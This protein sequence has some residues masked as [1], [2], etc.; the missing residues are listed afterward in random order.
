MREIDKDG[1]DLASGIWGAWYTATAVDD[2][3]NE[4]Q[5]FW[6]IL[7]SF[8]PDEDD[9][10]NACDWAKPWMVLDED[11]KNVVTDVEIA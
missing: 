2:E 5:V 3:M 9:E 8:N 6:E 1:N 4:Y 7:D 11:R 10:S